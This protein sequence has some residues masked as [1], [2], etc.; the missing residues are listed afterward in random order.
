M[1]RERLKH[2]L[3]SVFCLLAGGGIVI[4]MIFGRVNPASANWVCT[5]TAI[6]FSAL[7]IFYGIGAKMGRL[8][9]TRDQRFFANVFWITAI[10]SFPALIIVGI[11]VN[12]QANG[13]VDALLHGIVGLAFIAVAGVCKVL[14]SIREAELRL[15]ER[16]LSLRVKGD[17]DTLE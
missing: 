7:G 1:A 16:L 13:T 15:R 17:N 4:S 10:C 3:F 12:S 8:E 5:I 2:A 6:A 14:V 11:D 9:P